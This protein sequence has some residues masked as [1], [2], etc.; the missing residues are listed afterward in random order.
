M[1]M[2]LGQ[3]IM[4]LLCSSFPYVKPRYLLI[5]LQAQTSHQELNA[6]DEG[7]EYIVKN[8]TALFITKVKMLIYITNLI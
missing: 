7:S 5:E 2:M 6:L 8:I 3:I 4:I 1:W